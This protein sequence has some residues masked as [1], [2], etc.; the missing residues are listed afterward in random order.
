M[1]KL[2]TALAALAT[3]ALLAT[4]PAEAA[5]TFKDV[6]YQTE[7][8]RAIYNLVNDNVISGYQDGTFKPSATINRSQAAKILAG[9]LDLDVDNVKSPHFTDVPTTH[10]NYKYIAA[11]ANAGIIRS[12]GK[13]NPQNPVTRGQFS[14]ML[15]KG[16]KIPFNPVQGNKTY[17]ADVT[18]A[19]G[20]ADY[21]HT[22]YKAGYIKGVKPGYFAPSKTITRGQFAVMLNRAQLDSSVADKLDVDFLNRN[23]IAKASVYDGGTL[24]AYAD[25]RYVTQLKD[26]WALGQAGNR[27]F[28][29]PIKW[30]VVEA[31]ESKGYLAG[32]SKSEAPINLSNQSSSTQVLSTK[33]GDIVG[34]YGFLTQ[35]ISLGDMVMYRDGYVMPV[36]DIST[37]THKQVVIDK[38]YIQT[39]LYASNVGYVVN[40]Y[41]WNEASKKLMIVDSRTFGYEEPRIVQDWGNGSYLPF[42]K[43]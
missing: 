19:N 37:S 38:E 4:Q 27:I 43:R 15:V 23:N 9:A 21:I 6:D 11:L 39:Y 41:V 33:A 36:G 20:F 22:L 17:F 10:A 18:K 5:P 40:T 24:Y 29:G 30:Y 3:C 1:K 42:K 31:G 34:V 32:E 2:T 35:T 25:P 28:E 12:G 8:G 26:A 7:T 13:Y 16:A 14:Q